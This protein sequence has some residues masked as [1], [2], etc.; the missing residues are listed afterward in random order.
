MRERTQVS[1]LIWLAIFQGAE[2]LARSATAR[3]AQTDAF[4]SWL[5]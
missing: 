2:T 4:A 1:G 3:L 5:A